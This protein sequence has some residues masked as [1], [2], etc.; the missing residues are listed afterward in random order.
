M[1]SKSIG[2]LWKP[3][4]DNTNAPLAKGT[5]EVNGEKI[6]IVIWKAREKKT[7]K[8]P[9]YNITLDNSEWKQVESVPAKQD[10]FADDVPF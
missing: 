4:T 9:D 7:E 6:K 5:I 1:E 2:A 10:G 8:H 3:K